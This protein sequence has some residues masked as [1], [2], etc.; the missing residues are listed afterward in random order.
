MP[1]AR[2]VALIMRLQPTAQDSNGCGMQHLA[3]MGVLLVEARG[4][5]A[6]QGVR[7]RSGLGHAYLTEVGLQHTAQQHLI[8]Q[9]AVLES[10]SLQG[11][12]AGWRV[13]LF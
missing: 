5:A 4:L 12:C 7:V 13:C 6:L 1:C 2:R 10:R 3:R 8:D 11:A 9:R